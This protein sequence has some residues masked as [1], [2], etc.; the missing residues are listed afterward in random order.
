MFIYIYVVNKVAAGIKIMEKVCS[1][2]SD[3]I[4]SRNGTYTK[5]E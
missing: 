3:T 4:C 2:E 1:H 5:R